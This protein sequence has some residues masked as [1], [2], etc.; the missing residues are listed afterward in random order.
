[1]DPR[2]TMAEIVLAAYRF[3]EIAIVAQNDKEATRESLENLLEHCQNLK[4]WMD[5]DGFI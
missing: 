2:E 3:Q 1:M 4:Q 5:K